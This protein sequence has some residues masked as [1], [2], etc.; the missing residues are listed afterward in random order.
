MFDFCKDLYLQDEDASPS[1]LSQRAARANQVY[2][3]KNHIDDN[4]KN[5]QSGK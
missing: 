5:L 2:R 1:A 4:T 3:Q